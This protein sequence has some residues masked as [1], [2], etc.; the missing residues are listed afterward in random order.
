MRKLKIYRHTFFN[1]VLSRC[2]ASLSLT[3]Y[4]EEVNIR[5]FPNKRATI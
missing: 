1:L 3:E 4:T 2:P 5:T